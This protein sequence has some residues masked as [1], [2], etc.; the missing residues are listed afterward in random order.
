MLIMTDN[1]MDT[2]TT[3]VNIPDQFF[4]TISHAKFL[5][6]YDK[7]VARLQSKSRNHFNYSNQ[8]ENLHNF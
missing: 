3:P 8:K 2:K 1:R 7:H 6:K 5:F 4:K